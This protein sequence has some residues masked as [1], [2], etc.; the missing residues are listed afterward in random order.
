MSWVPE[1]GKGPR[2]GLWGPR[3]A[4]GRPGGNCGQSTPG[5]SLGEPRLHRRTERPEP[6]R[7]RVGRRFRGR[8]RLEE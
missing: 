8:W 3:K 2:E 6:T 4:W 7:H 1:A 5:R